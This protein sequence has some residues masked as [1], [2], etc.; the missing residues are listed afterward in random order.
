MSD[1]KKNF[2]SS[3]NAEKKN[4][5]QLADNLYYEGQNVNDCATKEE[6]GEGEVKVNETK[7]KNFLANYNMFF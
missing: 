1:S 5:G 3:G 6:R 4:E 7:K 2:F